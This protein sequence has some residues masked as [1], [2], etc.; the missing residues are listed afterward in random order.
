MPKITSTSRRLSI[1]LASA[2]VSLAA[3]VGA[4]ASMADAGPDYQTENPNEGQRADRQ[5]RLQ[6]LL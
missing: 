2:L 5:A 1:V 3:L 4:A 6:R